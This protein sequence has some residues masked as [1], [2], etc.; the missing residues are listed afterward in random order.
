M[1]EWIEGHKDLGQVDVCVPNAGFSHP[2]SL[3]DG[4]IVMVNSMS[5]HRVTMASKLKFY[6]ATKF[7]VTALVEGFRQELRQ[8][9]PKNKI[10]IAQ[11]CPGLVSTEFGAVSGAGSMFDNFKEPLT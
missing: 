10:R 1:F 4:S 7:A 2:G 8:M 5:G 3:M 6:S 9:E 11:L